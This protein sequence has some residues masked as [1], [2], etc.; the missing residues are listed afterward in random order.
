MPSWSTFFPDNIQPVVKV[1]HHQS[2]NDFDFLIGEWDI[3]NRILSQRLKGDTTWN[4]SKAYSRCWEILEGFGNMDEFSMESRDGKSFLGNSIRIF[5]PESEEW[6]IYWVDNWNLNKG[7]THQTKGKFD[8]VGTFYGEDLYEGRKVKQ[9]F[10]WKKIDE[11][12]A[13]WEQAY[14]YEEQEIWEVNWTMTF[15][16]LSP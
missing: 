10:T 8:G 13:Y 4:E 2:Q 6:N 5:D 14:W 1:N 16:R 15:Q 7:V 11:D 12:T 9:K 3:T